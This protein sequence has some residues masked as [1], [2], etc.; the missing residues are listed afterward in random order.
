MLML[1]VGGC[2]IL[3]CHSSLRVTEKP[4]IVLKGDLTIY[5]VDWDVDVEDP[6]GSQADADTE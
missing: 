1:F 5:G 3:G 2:L 6:S 4:A